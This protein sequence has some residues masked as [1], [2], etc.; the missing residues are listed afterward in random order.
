MLGNKFGA[1][2]NAKLFIYDIYNTYTFLTVTCDNN[3]EYGNYCFD[4]SL[5]VDGDYV[6]LLIN[7]F[8]IEYIN[9]VSITNMIRYYLPYCAV[10]I[11]IYFYIYRYIGRYIYQMVVYIQEIIK[12]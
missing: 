9:D 5:N 12:Q 3:P 6:K 7:G 1:S 4:S 8:M 10:L 2:N 11:S